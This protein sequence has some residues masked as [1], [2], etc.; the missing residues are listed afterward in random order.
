MHCCYVII[1]AI[2]M[3]IVNASP[4]ED[5]AF[6]EVARI[7]GPSPFAFDDGV[8]SNNKWDHVLSGKEYLY[9]QKA[10]KPVLAKIEKAIDEFYPRM[11]LPKTSRNDFYYRV[12]M[13]MRQV[14]HVVSSSSS[15]DGCS[16]GTT[17]TK[18]ARCGAVWRCLKRTLCDHLCENNRIRCSQCRAS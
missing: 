1:C 15:A 9:L 4:I 13:A 10:R 18:E 17:T 16:G 14:Y 2:L 6:A 8:L 12:S 11:P 5:H 3:S 7:L